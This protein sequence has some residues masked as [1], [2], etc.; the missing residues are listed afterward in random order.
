MSGKKKTR[1][2]FPHE[3]LNPQG[4]GRNS[5]LMAYGAIFGMSSTGVV[6]TKEFGAQ[7][8]V[9][10][11]QKTR[12]CFPCE[13]PKLQLRAGIVLL[14]LTERYLECLNRGCKNER[15]WCPEEGEQESENT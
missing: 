3:R 10:R 13:R 2:R 5:P 15:S 4:E 9:S 8:R 1:I 12:K 11:N 14:W 7:K 6:K